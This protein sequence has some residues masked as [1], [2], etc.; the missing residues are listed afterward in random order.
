M[1]PNRTEQT[2]AQRYAVATIG[3]G[4]DHPMTKEV[5]IG[6]MANMYKQGYGAARELPAGTR[7]V[8]EPKLLWK[9]VKALEWHELL[10]EAYEAAE[11]LWKDRHI[12]H[13]V[14]NNPKFWERPKHEGNRPA[15]K[16]T[17]T[18]QD[19]KRAFELGYTT[20]AE[21]AVSESVDFDTP[22]WVH[23]TN[24]S[25]FLWGQLAWDRVLAWIRDPK[26]RA[27]TSS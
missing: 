26:W 18:E 27:E 10:E 11:W 3:E 16:A 15:K 23:N 14:I 7:M 17:Y 5:V 4:F 8:D 2:D 13:E 6:L 22:A 1:N 21:M 25:L 24:M 12:I 19:L 9:D 20:C